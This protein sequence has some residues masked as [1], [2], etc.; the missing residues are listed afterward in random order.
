MK[1]RL[2][3]WVAGGLGLGLFAATELPPLDEVAGL[4]RT[5]LP[6]VTAEQ[7]QAGAVESLLGRLSN[8]VRL[9]EDY[10][11]PG[12]ET[13]AVAATRLFEERF[14]YLRRG[15]VA[16]D[17]GTRTLERLTELRT[18]R[19]E[20]S[21]VVLDLR[22]AG[23]RDF[24]VAAQLAGLFLPASTPLFDAGDGILMSPLATNRFEGPLAVLVNARTHGAAE[25]V[26]KALQ[27]QGAALLVGEATAGDAAVVQ[28]PP[29]TT[30]QRLRLTVSRL[31][32]ANG[33]SVPLSGV[34][35]DLRLSLVANA[36][37]AYPRDPFTVAIS[38]TNSPT[39]TNSI[40]ATVRVRR[41]VNEA[42]SVRDRTG[43]N[44]I[45]RPPETPAPAASVIRDLV[46]ARGLDFLKGRIL[47]S[48]QA[49]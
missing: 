15:E 28:D 40:T 35:P 18:G 12:L 44:H 5:H 27:L 7:L 41:R 19:L 24:S 46:L 3:A 39:A 49:A 8:R 4:L 29:L 17:A 31:K 43:T 32:F 48:A 9:L 20:G 25:A 36:E 45:A 16:R 42:E 26:A 1:R 22:F 33:Q 34:E 23:G 10:E 13:S 38:R 37:R 47:L 2:A 30:G 21:G 6:G 11:E 14:A